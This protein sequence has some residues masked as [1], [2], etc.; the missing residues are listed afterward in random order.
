ME[1]KKTI[2]KIIHSYFNGQLNAEK[3][4][5]LSEWIKA[6][7]KNKKFFESV[8]KK[9]RAESIQHQLI[10]QSWS[11][12]QSRIYINNQ[13]KSRKQTLIRRLNTNFTRVAAVVLAIVG[14]SFLLAQIMP[15]FDQL[16][17]EISWFETVAPR[18]EKSMISLPDGSKVWLNS[19]TIIQYPS[20]YIEG[21]RAIRLTGE[22]YF[23]VEKFKGSTFTVKTN[24]YTV[25]VL[26]TKF[27]V[28]AYEDFNRTETSL[29][30]GKVRIRHKNRAI[31]M[32]PG[33]ELSF[34]D[35][36]FFLEKKDTRQ[37][38]RWKDDT[39]DFNR[40]PL[41]ELVRR[42][43]R[44][45]DVEIN[46]EDNELKETIYSGVFKNE[47][48]IWQVLNIL[49]LTLPIE[50]ERTDFRKIEIKQKK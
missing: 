21:N 34:Q 38:T 33:Q 47:E 18:G 1:N 24:D 2:E 43:E 17:K 19:E 23:E 36:Q 20:N 6:D 8:K 26:G 16:N 27:N 11:E 15:R 9:L 46:M 10:D 40:V 22:A 39:F 5:E 49:Q 7:S 32:E 13:F 44:W 28:M 30:E 35:N 29:I 25:E 3:E 48:T 31:E 50:Y 45:Y 37:S 4:K 41:N 12:L 42:L 14:L